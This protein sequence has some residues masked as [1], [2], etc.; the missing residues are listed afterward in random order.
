MGNSFSCIN[1]LKGCNCLS[2]PV[3]NELSMKDDMYCMK[4]SEF[5][6]RY[7]NNMK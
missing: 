2:C 3:E 7:V 6:N 4:G 5:E 1:E